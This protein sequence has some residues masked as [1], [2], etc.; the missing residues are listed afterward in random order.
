MCTKYEGMR[1]CEADDAD[2]HTNWLRNYEKG[3]FT[4][5]KIFVVS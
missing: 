5:R 3:T 1:N 4:F 2:E